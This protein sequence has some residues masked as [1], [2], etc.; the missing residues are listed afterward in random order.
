MPGPVM[1][2][3]VAVQLYIAHSPPLRSF[4]SSYEEYRTRNRV[5]SHFKPL[6]PCLSPKTQLGVPCLGWQASKNKAKKK[7]VFADSKGMSLTAVHVFSSPD[8]RE[9]RTLSRL[10]FVDDL[11]TATAALRINTVQ[12]RVLDFPQPAAD[13][14]DFRKHLTKNSVCLENCT[15]QERALTGTVKVRNLAFEKSVQVRI[16]FDSWKTYQDIECSYMNNVYGCQD[17]DTF[18]FALELPAYIPPLEK[19]EFC[20]S[21]VAG[22]HTHW[23]N[24]DG[25]NY[26]LVPTTWKTNDKQMKTE[27]GPKIRGWKE[28]KF[29]QLNSSVN[30]WNRLFPEC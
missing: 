1:P 2:V 19:V 6:R 12:S 11:E 22:G 7:V 16:T 28:K 27:K 29:G 8:S 25:R 4:L 10:Q 9:A 13:Y 14:V 30:S 20:L 24:N 26:G 3:D 5:N 17:T 15:L 18:S 21:Y 23:D